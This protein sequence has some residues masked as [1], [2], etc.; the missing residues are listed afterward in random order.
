[1]TE[2]A[3]QNGGGV[4]A[5]VRNH[6]SFINNHSGV[7]EKFCAP[8]TRADALQA[9]VEHELNADEKLRACTPASVYLALMACAVTGL[10]PGKLRGL[11]YLIPFGNQATFMIG[12]RGYKYQAIR[13][14]LDFQSAVIRQ[15]DDFDFDKGTLAFV[16][17]KPALGGGGEIIGS[18]AWCKMPRGGLELEWLDMVAL[19]AVQKAA[20]KRAPSPAW[21]GDFRDQ[22]MRKSALRR[23]GK[24]VEMGEEFYKA[25]LVERSMDEYGTL[26]TG[27]DVV[28]DGAATRVLAQQSVEAAAFGAAPRPP[29][30][31]VKT[32][33]VEAEARPTSA[34]AGAPS[35]TSSASTAA[36]QSSTP[37]RKN[38]D[39][40]RAPRTPRGERPTGSSA[41]SSPA[42]AATSST[43]GEAR[44]TSAAGSAGHAATPGTASS[45]S[46]SP[47]ASDTQPSQESTVDPMPAGSS[48]PS[49]TESPASTASESTS[50][51]QGGAV[52]D[53]PG[54]FDDDT[55]A[56]DPRSMAGF[57]AW[58]L[59]CKTKKELTD[60]KNDWLAWARDIMGWKAADKKAGT[61]AS[62]EVV[63]MQKAFAE[64]YAQVK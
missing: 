8:G 1:M 46:E 29:Q 33:V 3:N 15:R 31:Q 62:P 45:P 37:A 60:G 2:L 17:Y 30:A 36:T 59:S 9:Y 22:M 25:D 40:E 14:G 10:L 34:S 39:A 28:T 47:S 11:A 48:A 6:M 35:T 51:S 64:R 57:K 27:L 44:P 63:E 20:E 53:E 42:A 4:V 55:P 32:T 61:P 26:A 58:C 13:A 24:Q 56:E 12:W 16:R 7:I 52:V 21:R 38:S 5:I 50:E 18:A 49:N 43:S 23:L 54:M 41:G 19:A